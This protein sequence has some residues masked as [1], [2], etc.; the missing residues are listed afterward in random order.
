MP[1]LPFRD[2]DNLRHYDYIENLIT[3]IDRVIEKNLPGIFISMDHSGVST[4]KLVSYIAN[5]L[6]KK[7]IMIKLPGI[8]RRI[9]KLF[10]QTDYERLF[11]SLIIDNSITRK[12]LNYTPLFSTREGI[13]RTLNEN[14]LNRSE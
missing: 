2:T 14:D 8:F 11:G 12:R 6:G 13:Y 4:E 5:S 1:V 7:V 10:F 3:L 9:V